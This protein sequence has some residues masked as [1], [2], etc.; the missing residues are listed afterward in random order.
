MSCVTYR[1]GGATEGPRVGRAEALRE[2]L[3]GRPDGAPPRLTA[4]PPLP[5]QA[6]QDIAT[7]L[8]EADAR[9]CLASADEN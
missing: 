9:R 4:H 3:T 8:C 7:L 1:Y 5:S 6:N 2:P